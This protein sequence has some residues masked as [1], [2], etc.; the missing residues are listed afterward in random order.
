LAVMSKSTP[1]PTHPSCAGTRSTNVPTS[2]E[3]RQASRT[4]SAR[5]TSSLS[6]NVPVLETLPQ[7]PNFG[8]PVKGLPDS[9][10][11]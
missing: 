9:I 2:L 3:A 8:L 5:T 1:A 10:G 7:I 11:R 4:V 6:V